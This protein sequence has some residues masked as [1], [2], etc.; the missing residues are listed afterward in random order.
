MS[1]TMTGSRLSNLCFLAGRDDR[2]EFDEQLHNLVHG[3]KTEIPEERRKF[4][5]HGYQN[6]DDAYRKV[7]E[8]L[9]LT[10]QPQRRTQFL[11]D[12]KVW[13]IKVGARSDGTYKRPIGPDKREHGVLEIKSP[14]FKV[15]ETVTPYH[16][17][18]LTLEMK[19]YKRRHAL[20]VSHL[21]REGVEEA[22]HVF[23]VHW[24]DA[25]WSHAETLF[26]ALNSGAD[27][28][29]T[30]CAYNEWATEWIA[31]KQNVQ[32]TYFSAEPAQK[33]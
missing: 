24:D 22:M 10:L 26:A 16:L 6:E 30:F 18:Q 28:Y 23:N 20:F 1:T 29:E 32:L 11:N 14:Y 4:I 9:Q 19:C 12:T 33:N 5:E 15:H 3:I 31:D 7:G 17:A 25:L 27:V 2:A 21:H 13:N 8:R